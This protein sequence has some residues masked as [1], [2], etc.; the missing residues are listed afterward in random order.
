M[1]AEEAR[2]Q[3]SLGELGKVMSIKTTRG[4]GVP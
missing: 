1:G 4:Y 3:D 2:I